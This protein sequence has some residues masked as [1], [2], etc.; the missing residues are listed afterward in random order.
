MTSARL[1]AFNVM[2][3]EADLAKLLESER[4]NGLLS[5]GDHDKRSADRQFWAADRCFRRE[6]NR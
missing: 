2:K 6:H 1:T 4:P 5:A 3:S